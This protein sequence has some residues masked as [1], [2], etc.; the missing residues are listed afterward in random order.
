MIPNLKKHYGTYSNT[1][2][3][4]AVVFRKIPNDE[5]N[6]ILID[7]DSLPEF[8]QDT[9]QQA[10]NSKD[11]LD[12]NDFH[13]VLN[14]RTFPDGSNALTALH[15][16]GFLKKH[17]IANITMLPVHGQ[18]V[19]L[20]IINASIDNRM[21]EVDA[22]V[23][24]INDIT[25]V[26]NKAIAQ[27]LLIQAD[28]L[29]KESELKREEAYQLCPEL[30]PIAKPKKEKTPEEIEAAIARTKANR[31]EGDRRRAAKAKEAKKDAEISAKAKA[32]IKRDNIRY[33]AG[34]HPIVTESD[35]D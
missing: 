18:E 11:A 27:G 19:A 17:P 9:I 7:I 24:E 21:I 12:T 3:R 13:I 6:C 4:V 14:A 35:V 23:S 22:D 5:Q 1:G 30:K 32:K 29:L 31:L 8:Y 10:L 20:E 25:P 16:R 26:D 2:G 34:V 15:Q 33:K 28:M